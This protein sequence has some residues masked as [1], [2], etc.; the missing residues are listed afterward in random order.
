MLLGSI[1]PSGLMF[2]LQRESPPELV[3]KLDGWSPQS[4][5]IVKSYI[6]IDHD[7]TVIRL[8]NPQVIVDTLEAIEE[9]IAE[10]GEHPSEAVLRA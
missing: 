7:T 8:L 2:H 5:T 10:V 9:A 3:V 6:R 1:R 4:A